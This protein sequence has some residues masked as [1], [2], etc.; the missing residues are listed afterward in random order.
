LQTPTSKVLESK[1]DA[2]RL[3]TPNRQRTTANRS[4]TPSRDPSIPRAVTPNRTAHSVHHTPK[5]QVQPVVL[6]S[7]KPSNN[8]KHGS[9]PKRTSSGAERPLCQDVTS[10]QTVPGTT[11]F[12][13]GRK[14][15]TSAGSLGSRERSRNPLLLGPA[16][17]KN[18]VRRPE[19]TMSPGPQPVM[20]TDRKSQP[21]TFVDVLSERA[22]KSPSNIFE[23][24]Q[25]RQ[26]PQI[27][28]S[29]SIRTQSISTAGIFTPDSASLTHRRGIKSLRLTVKLINE[30]FVVDVR[31]QHTIPLHLRMPQEVR[32]DEACAI[33][34]KPVSEEKIQPQRSSSASRA[35]RRTPA[36]ELLRPSGK[37]LA[38]STRLKEKSQAGTVLASKLPGPSVTIKAGSSGNLM[39][40]TAASRG[41]R[42]PRGT[43]DSE[44]ESNNIF[45]ASQIISAPVKTSAQA[46][47]KVSLRS[48]AVDSQVRVQAA[49]TTGSKKL[50]QTSGHS[51]T[52]LQLLKQ[53]YQ[54]S[55]QQTQPSSVSLLKSSSSSLSPFRVHNGSRTDYAHRDPSPP[56][57][58]VVPWE[59]AFSTV[60]ETGTSSCTSSL[61]SISTSFMY[62]ALHP[63]EPPT[64]HK[65]EP[66]FSLAGSSRTPQADYQRLHRRAEELR[67]GRES[68][69]PDT[70][71]QFV[72]IVNAIESNETVRDFGCVMATKQ[73]QPTLMDFGVS[74]VGWG[75]DLSEAEHNC[76]YR[77][78]SQTSFNSSFV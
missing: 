49:A 45:F 19:R 28:D 65:Y 27:P 6:M 69:E 62:P 34:A 70:M 76:E 72:Q 26:S 30:M 24:P 2:I 51:A 56:I 66:T 40:S 37:V 12:H 14:R 10:R 35:V 20:T 73:V 9:T 75:T 43:K 74:P 55:R 22:F 23:T 13:E 17:C 77:F 59:R 33:R 4:H 61:E 42:S 57:G 68:L 39:S 38:T 8:Q 21:E 63:Q 11:A 29:I 32:D 46:Q 5:L 67:D 31:N 64:Y 52:Q 50:V 54:S 48:G 18:S 44:K 60:A 78:I 36:E 7:Q 25:R 58:A 47:S 1:V 53:K 71:A 15:A 41:H 3:N 16:E